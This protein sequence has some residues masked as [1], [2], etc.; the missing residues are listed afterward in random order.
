[1]TDVCYFD[2]YY[3]NANLMKLTEDMNYYEN[4]I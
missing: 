3:F 2:D 4:Y 1:M